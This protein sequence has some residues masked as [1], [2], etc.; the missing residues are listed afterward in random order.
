MS[1]NRNVPPSRELPSGSVRPTW[2]IVFWRELRDLWVGGKALTLILMYSVLLGIYSYMLAANAEVNLLP[3]REMI[4]EMVKASIAVGAFI[5]LI[6]AA[7]SFSGERE[8]GTL[9]TMLLTPASRRQIA[10]GKFLAAVSPWP[11]ALAIAIPYW[12][13]LSKGDPVFGQALL[14]GS[15]LGSLLA[16]AMAGLGML[17]SMWCNSNKTS[18]LVSLCLFLLVLLPTELSRPWRVETP[19]EMKR[20]LLYS[21]VNPWDAA[22]RFLSLIFIK[23]SPF[24]EVWFVPIL[25]VVFAAGILALFVVASRRLRLDPGIGRKLRSIGERLG[26]TG[27]RSLPRPARLVHEAPSEAAVRLPEVGSP[28]SRPSRRVERRPVPTGPGTPTW[29]V[30]LK[31]ELGDLWIGGKALHLTVLYTVVLGVYAYITARDST[32][33]LVPPKEMVYELTKAAIVASVFVGLIIGADSLSGERERATL[34]GLLLTPT[35]RLQIVVGKFLA[36]ASPGPAAL[37]ITIPYMKVLSQGDEVFGQAVL[38]GLGLGCVLTLAFT[39]MAMFVGFWCNSNKTSLF[40][41][42]CLYLLFFLPTQLPGHAQGGTMGL[43]GQ[44]MNPLAAPRVFLA[45][46]LVNNWTLARAWSW[47]LSPLAFA[48]LTFGLLFWY[49]GP[50]LRLEAGKARRFQGLRGRMAALLLM[51]SL[52]AFGA[53]PA[54]ALRQ[55]QSQATPSMGPQLTVSVDVETKD[56]RAGTPIQFNTVLANTGTEATPALIVAMNI[57][58]LSKSGDVVD[59]EDWSPQRTQYVDPLRAGQSASLGWRINAIL[60]GD[61]MVYM[62]AIPAPVGPGATSHPVA[63]PGIHLRV[64]KYARLNPGG[65]LPYAIGGPIVLGL[66]I[67]LVYRYRHRQI[68]AG[69]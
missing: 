42:L 66:L 4:L 34:E 53:S 65:V 43:F 36:A 51:V 30:V 15:V 21:F 58:N 6:I 13:V 62:V 41:S 10:I 3:L 31:K 49:A 35:S 54:M 52:L 2:S 27:R 48:V 8:R 16:P 7:D 12:A 19:A 24:G 39:A 57:I 59:P 69:G 25:C 26:A 67:F 20:G 64:S 29:W 45:S 38:W 11:V 1:D 55:Q 60:D 61:Y 18:M 17:V 63:S 56:V 14:W 68:D 9:E 22:S 40:I 44:W 32:L 23:R 5:C 50:A 37:A 33:S 46:L 47:L 28:T